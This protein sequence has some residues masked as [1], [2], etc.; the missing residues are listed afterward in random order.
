MTKKILHLYSPPALIKRPPV[1]RGI[2]TQTELNSLICYSLQWGS[3][4]FVR[5][6]FQWHQCY[7][8]FKIVK[9]SCAGVR[10]CTQTNPFPNTEEFQSTFY[11]CL[12][13]RLQSAYLNNMTCFSSTLIQRGSVKVCKSN[14]YFIDKEDIDPFFNLKPTKW[15]DIHTPCPK[16]RFRCGCSRTINRA[17]A[18]QQR[19]RRVVEVVRPQIW[20]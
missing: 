11:F 19:A 20:T 8:R 6:G 7:Y 17:I 14:F 1:W 3:N 13:C 10:L 2:K 4:Y 5:G 9:K 12:L 18:Q 16:L 15:T